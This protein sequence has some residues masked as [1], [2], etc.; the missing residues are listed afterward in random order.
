MLT[1]HTSVVPAASTLD[2]PAPAEPGQFLNIVE[3]PLDP[4]SSLE[5]AAAILQNQ[6]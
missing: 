4:A 5:S 2:L 3:A 1:E 6:D